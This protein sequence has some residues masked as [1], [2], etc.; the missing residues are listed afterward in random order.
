MGYKNQHQ[1]ANICWQFR[2]WRT[3]DSAVGKTV[4]FVTLSLLL[5]K[6]CQLATFSLRAKLIKFYLLYPNRRN[7]AGFCKR[8]AERPPWGIKLSPMGDV[9]ETDSAVGVAPSVGLSLVKIV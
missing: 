2:N 9:F 6:V 7:F 5:A 8:L 4:T 3:C 1:N